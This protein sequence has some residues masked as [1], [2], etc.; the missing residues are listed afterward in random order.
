LH[1]LLLHGWLIESSIT[2]Q[3]QRIFY[4]IL[5]LLSIAKININIYFMFSI[6]PIPLNANYPTIMIFLNKSDYDGSK[7]SYRRHRREESKK[8][9]PAE[10]RGF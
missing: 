1:G 2:T 10:T 8:R 3:N 5:Q 9:V 4:S 7:N 6:Y